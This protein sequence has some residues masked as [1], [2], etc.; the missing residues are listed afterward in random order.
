[1]W[2]S[3]QPRQPSIWTNH[4]APTQLLTVQH[5]HNYSQPQHNY[6][7]PNTTTHAQHNYSQPNTT[8]HSPN[9]TTHSPNTTT[10]SPNTTTHSPNTTT[11][12]PNT[13]THSPNTTTS[14]PSTT[15]SIPMPTP[16]T[17]MTMGKYNVSDEKGT[18][19]MLEMA[20]GIRVNT[21]KVRCFVLVWLIYIQMWF[22]LY[23]NHLCFTLSPCYFPCSI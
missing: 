9:T 17:N 2:P 12:S 10:H 4:T 21:S 15:T 14:A 7:Q 20:I 13:T 16:S 5:T 23:L 6:S 18:C 19:I 1:M 11:H 3:V 22:S 8:T